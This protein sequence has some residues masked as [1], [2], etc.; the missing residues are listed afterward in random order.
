MD[1]RTAGTPI[2]KVLSGL[3]EQQRS[4]VLH[5]HEPLLVVA[6]AGT[7]KTA[8]LAHRVAHLIATGTDP[9]HILLLTFTRR[10]AAEMLRRVDEILRLLET[11]TLCQETAAPAPR[12]PASAP[13][14]SARIWG[15]TFHAIAVRLLRLHGRG[16]G[17]DPSFTILD[18][19]DAEDLM[20]ML[21]TELGLAKSDRRFPLKSTCTDIYSRCVNARESVECAVE[22]HFPWCKEEVADLRRLFEAYVDHK[23]ETVRARLRRPPALLARS[24][25][26]APG[27][28]V[29]Q[30]L[31]SSTSSSMST[32]TP[33]GCSRTSCN[34]SLPGAPTSLWWAMMPRPSTPFG[35]P[36]LTTSWSSRRSSPA[37]AWSP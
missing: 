11:Q 16:I 7:G 8:T 29:S 9:G 31:A 15:G 27:G 21:R 3:N 36:P 23:Q 19:V 12:A 32:K 34:S 14:A 13:A 35:P 17:L 28:A 18:R 33:T 4:A 6:G 26:R 25:L 10:A 30:G 37:P 5:G 1:D 20:G 22:E 2:G 24:T